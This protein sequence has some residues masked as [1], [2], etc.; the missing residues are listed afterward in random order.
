LDF[1]LSNDFLPEI[2]G[3]HLILYEVYKRWGSEVV[4]LTGCHPKQKE[5]DALGHGSLRIQR[6]EIKKIEENSSNVD[7]LKY[8][9]SQI[10]RLY[11]SSKNNI[12][13]LHCLRALPEG[14]VGAIWKCLHP[15]SSRLIVYAHGEELM[16]AKSSRIYRAITRFVFRNSDLIIAN[17]SNTRSLVEEI[18]PSAPT[19]RI[20]PGVNLDSFRIIGEIEKYREELSLPKKAIIVSTIARME[21]R[22]NHIAVMKA[23]HQLRTEGLNIFYVCGTDG[24]ERSRIEDVCTLLGLREAVQFTGIVSETKKAQILKCSDIFAMPSIQVGPMLEGFG[25]VFLEAAAAGIPSI[26]GNTGGQSEAVLHGETGFVIDGNDINA[27]KNAIRVL[28]LDKNLRNNM[29]TKGREWATLN[30][31]DNVV[32]TVVQ[33]IRHTRNSR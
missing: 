9:L 21:A 4:L 19:I 2:G 30:S 7:L 11:L 32:A 14:L 13:N 28:A 29:G 20:H 22:K 18:C 16:V 15:I 23:V 27:L 10:N 17:S 6:A 12:G 26:A 33:A 8:A 31:W 1:V 25:I 5:F 24:P 3:A